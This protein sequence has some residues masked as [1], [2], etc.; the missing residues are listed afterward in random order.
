MNCADLTVE[1]SVDSVAAVDGIT[2]CGAQDWRS[3][4]CEGEERDLEGGKR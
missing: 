1:N 3:R 2:A 4:I